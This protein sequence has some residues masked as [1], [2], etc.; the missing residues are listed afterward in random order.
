VLLAGK[1]VS[2]SGITPL[3]EM[4]RYERSRQGT[5][6]LAEDPPL[7]LVEEEKISQGSARNA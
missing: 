4:M 3:V 5:R 1:T 2:T 6:K 7:S